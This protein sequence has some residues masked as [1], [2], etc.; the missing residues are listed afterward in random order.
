MRGYWY[1]YW[2][3]HAFIGIATLLLIYFIKFY[4]LDGEDI[5]LSIITYFRK[6]K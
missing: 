3:E 1:W 4:I 2:Y 5:L 6:K